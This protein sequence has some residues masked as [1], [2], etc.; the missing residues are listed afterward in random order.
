MIHIAIVCGNGL[1]TSTIAENNI[2]RALEKKGIKAELRH[3]SI[4]ILG[5]LDKWADII[6]VLKQ[7]A[8]AARDISS[9]PNIIEMVSVMNGNGI[10]DQI[11]KIMAERYPDFLD[12]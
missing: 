12:V 10:A 5:S 2:R 1:G 9:N 8:P 4:G 11:E 6:C 7:L 3:G